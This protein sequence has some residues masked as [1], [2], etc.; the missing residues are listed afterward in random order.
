MIE[1]RLKS[2]VCRFFVC[3]RICIGLDN[4]KLSSH[5]HSR[6][7][8]IVGPS[9][10]LA[11]CY[12]EAYLPLN[13]NHDTLLHITSGFNPKQHDIHTSIRILWMFWNSME[14]EN[15]VHDPFPL[16]VSGRRPNSEKFPPN[17]HT[18]QSPLASMG[19]VWTPS[20]YLGEHQYGPNCFHWFSNYSP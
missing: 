14:N 4:N 20:T 19:P 11:Q 15:V 7:Y 3:C 5:Y 17:A 13:C 12:S 8:Q 2:N 18:H 10:K 16:S 9:L 1:K 6:L